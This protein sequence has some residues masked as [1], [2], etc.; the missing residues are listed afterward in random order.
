M[1][2]NEVEEDIRLKVSNIEHDTDV[3]DYE[4]VSLEFAGRTIIYLTKLF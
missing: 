1:Y 2:Q 3:L 4:N